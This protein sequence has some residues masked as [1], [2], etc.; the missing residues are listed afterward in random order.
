MGPIGKAD[1]IGLLLW[2]MCVLCVLAVPVFAQADANNTGE[3]AYV[4]P[5][6]MFLKWNEIDT[7]AKI[8]EQR[9]KYLRERGWELSESAANPGQH[10]WIGWG[11]APIKLDPEDVRYGQARI[12][13]LDRAFAVATGAFVL[14]EIP[15]V[16]T[17]RISEFMDDKLPQDS[18]GAGKLPRLRK[19]LSVAA[20]KVMALGEGRLD[21]E[22]RKVGVDPDGYSKVSAVEKR[23]KMFCEDVMR[24]VLTEASHSLRGLRILTSF[25]DRKWVGV[26]VAYSEE[27]EQIARHFVVG[28]VVSRR[29]A[30]I[31]RS[32]IRDQLAKA[33]P[34]NAD[35][36]GV[37]GVRIMQDDSGE[38]VLVAFGQWAP[39]VTRTTSSS[40][41]NA[42]MEAAREMA[43]Q[44]AYGALT[45]FLKS[46][47]TFNAT[48]AR[49]ELEELSRVV[50]DGR[51]EEEQPYD[52]GIR[53]ARI[54]KQYGSA[55]LEGVQ[56]IKTWTA[57][58]PKTGHLYV[59]H[60]VILSPA[61]RD[62]VRG[63]SLKQPEGK[64]GQIKYDDEV[65]E[66]PALDH[67]DPT[68]RRP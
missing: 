21:A 63:R 51:V 43:R 49:R 47:G 8:E 15:K 20:E 17:K 12:A 48:A 65:I 7:G 64:S 13:A 2:L 24:E 38:N 37:H 39:A 58:H 56:P 28:E 18:S 61:T 53:V 16:T 31:V 33:L 36:I 14:S 22:L 6:N 32:S 41:L 44:D 62:A 34:N 29:P 55:T 26:L 11:M 27:S 10:V 35:Y 54:I 45:D 5:A 52:I 4:N 67:L 59:G 66:A 30:E 57:N 19:Q 50:L 46:T 40:V 60:A 9:D 68:L 1:G 25:E 42:E 3:K 23:Q